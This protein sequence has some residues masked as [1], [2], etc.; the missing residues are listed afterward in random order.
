M[1]LCVVSEAGARMC[2]SVGDPPNGILNV[3]GGVGRGVSWIIDPSFD[4]TGAAGVVV[5]AGP[6]VE[7]PPAATPITVAELL[8]AAD[9]DLHVWR[10]AIEALVA[11]IEGG[12]KLA[13]TDLLGCLM[14]ADLAVLLRETG[15]A[16]VEE[17]T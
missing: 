2:R 6:D 10:F 1:K 16:I 7:M 9:G 13:R 11:A 14:V 3:G 15:E 17:S 4:P 12:C 8:E 5:E